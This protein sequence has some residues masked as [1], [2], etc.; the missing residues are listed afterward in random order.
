MKPVFISLSPNTEW[1]DVYRAACLLV[2]PWQWRNA[3][4]VNQLEELLPAV[5]KRRSAVVLNSGR[6]ALMAIINT[7][8]LEKGDEVLVQGF[9]CNAL[10]NPIMWSGFK[11]RY[12]DI[13]ERTL[14]MDPAQLERAITERSR[15]VI[16]QHTFGIPAEMNAIQ[17]ICQRYNLIL[18][19]DCAH[20]IGGTYRGQQLGTFGR[21][22]FYSFGRDKVISSV[23]GGA[24]ATDDAELARGMEVYRDVLSVPSAWWTA[25]QL[26]HPILTKLVVMPLY[27]LGEVGRWKLAALQRIGVLSKA[28]HAR[29]KRGERPAYIPLR[30]P[31]ALAELAAA[32]LGKVER[33]NKHRQQMARVYTTALTDAEGVVLPAVHCEQPLM[34]YPVLLEN[35]D[36]SRILRR[37]RQKGIHLQDGWHGAAIVPPDTNQTAMQYR[38][39]MCPIA[40]R[41]AYQLVNLPTHSN[42]PIKNAADIAACVLPPPHRNE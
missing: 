10:T 16:V 34:R 7:L 21:A 25:K 39:G 26:L 41:V 24:A 1:D 14:N 19:E 9:T 28:V 8:P 5:T 18:L 36:P 6:A 13:D 17:D 40:E 30:L 15:V 3:A 33:F 2:Q 29:E 38:E 12:V 32:Q 23:Y 35:G 27:R 31:G 11:P 42:V 4:A 37:A 22:S 20:T